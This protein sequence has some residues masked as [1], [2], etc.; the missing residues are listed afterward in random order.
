MKNNQKSTDLLQKA[1]HIEQNLLSSMELS[2][3]METGKH[4]GTKQ[5]KII[6]GRLVMSISSILAVVATAAYLV[7]APV[8]EQKN[9]DNKVI[10]DVP[11]TEQVQSNTQSKVSE[12]IAN[13][14]IKTEDF[15]S[16]DNKVQDK[17]FKESS[18]RIIEEKVNIDGIKIISINSENDLEELG[19]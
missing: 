15:A 8:Q 5:T 12:I 14:D 6:T 16:S 3:I 17:P 10:N 7:F 9:I 18:F 11:K 4:L 2:E 13:K 1:K 19:I